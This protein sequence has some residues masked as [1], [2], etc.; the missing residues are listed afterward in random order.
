MGSIWCLSGVEPSRSTNLTPAFAAMSTNWMI[1][2]SAGCAMEYTYRRMTDRTATPPI[3]ART[4]FIAWHIV[5]LDF[6]D[7]DSTAPLP[8]K[9]P[10]PALGLLGP[11]RR[12]NHRGH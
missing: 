11:P 6:I 3:A 2:G 1:A 9:E 12:P 4:E 7:E 8:D 10:A 5:L